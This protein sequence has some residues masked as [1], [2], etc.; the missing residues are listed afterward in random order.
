MAETVGEIGLAL[1]INQS[2]FNRQLQGL[3]NTAQRTGNTLSNAL[4]G[5]GNISN[6]FTRN[7]E[8]PITSSFGVLGSGAKKLGGL[9]AGAFAISSI[10]EFVSSCLDLGSNLAEVQNVVDVT[11]TT[12][13]DSVN[14]FSTNAMTQFGLSETVA[15]KYMGTFGAMSKAFGFTEEQSYS[16]SKAVTGLTAD[17][18]SFYNLSTDEAYTKMKSIWT[19]ETESL[20]DLGVVMT[21]SALDSYALANGYG[22]TTS[23]MTEQEKVA[24]R[25]QFVMEQLSLA[26]GDFARTSNGW[27]NQTRVLALQFDS[28][29]ATLGQ[30]FINLFTPIV[31]GINLVIQRLQVLAEKFKSFTE[32]LVG[33]RNDTSENGIADSLSTATEKSDAL[34]DSATSTGKKV[35]NALMGFDEINKLS[36]NDEDTSST[37]TDLGLSANDLTPTNKALDNTKSKLNDILGIAKNIKDLFMEG[38]NIGFANTNFDNI[39][40]SLFNIKDSLKDIFTN[41][42]V[43]ASVENWANSFILNLGKMVG[44]ISSIGVTCAELLIGS[45]EKYLEQNKPRIIEAITTTFDISTDINNLVGDLFVSLADIF[46]VFRSDDAKQI[47]ANIINIFATSL[48]TVGLLVG[49]AVKNIISAFAVPIKNNVDKIK[50]MFSGLLGVLKTTTGSVSSIFSTAGDTF[51]DVYKNKLSPAYDRIHSASSEIFGTLFD[52][53]NNN[54]IPALQSLADKFTDVAD[55]YIKPALE[56]IINVFG[57]I[58]D[59]ISVLI[60]T[61]IKPIVQ[62]IIDEVVPIISNGIQLVGSIVANVIGFIVNTIKNII[63]IVSDVFSIIVGVVTGDGDKIKTA[64]FDIVNRIKDTFKGLFDTIKNIF[65]DIWDSIKTTFNLDAVGQHFTNIVNKIDT[66]VSSIKDKVKNTFQSAWDNIKDIFNLDNIK[67]HFDDIMTG[68]SNSIKG[69][70]NNVIDFINSAINGL[71]SIQIDV[72]DWLAEKTGISNFGLSIPNIPRL[73]NGGIVSQPTLAMVGE[74][75][76]AISNPEVI[77]PLDK[78]TDL[79]SNRGNN[80]DI[81]SAIERIA[82]LLAN[83]KAPQVNVDFPDSYV[84]NAIAKNNVRTG[85]R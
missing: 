33:N 12:M 40:K 64:F 65:A 77:A 43:V 48:S 62:W 7:V 69:G 80:S 66:T 42:D 23:K 57:D 74:Y 20:K 37:N 26:N 15:K 81:I 38:F 17:V 29:K 36:D 52:S 22:K 71:N 54:I 21:Q 30:G 68:I 44:S 5:G 2:E 76:G 55:T 34:G 56:D 32:F 1:G 58:V 63:G 18:A 51:Q 19:G 4:T 79:I 82:E 67:S 72:P 8:N 27:A 50:D 61:T 47:G 53:I 46:T 24:L 3:Q 16:M 83:Q 73:A 49:V 70:L 13:S 11:F 59:N 75:S 10:K 28:L 14:N 35:K 78:L 9:I 25:Y 39:K 84:S 60:D 45:A 85:G 31:Q 6:T 41:S